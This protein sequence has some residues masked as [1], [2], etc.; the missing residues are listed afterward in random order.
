MLRRR[1][2]AAPQLVELVR[3]AALVQRREVAARLAALARAGRGE[4][5]PPIETVKIGASAARFSRSASAA[6]PGGRRGARAGGGGA[7]RGL[8]C[9][10]SA[11]RCQVCA[12][13][14]AGRRGQARGSPE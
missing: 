6:R 1:R 2:L 11:Q 5:L 9:G 10:G 7:R 14:G 12:R 13:G 8:G 3:G 4:P